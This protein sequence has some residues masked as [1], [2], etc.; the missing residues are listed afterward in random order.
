MVSS[1]ELLDSRRLT[2]PNLLGPSPGAV[3]DVRIE[4]ARATEFVDA[5]RERMT[6]MLDAIGWGGEETIVRAFEGGVNLAITAP[7]D[8]LYAA[9]EVNEWAVAAAGGDGGDFEVARARLAGEI[10]R[11]RDPALLALDAAATEHGVRFLSD[12]EFVSVGSGRGSQTW[13]A[14]ELPDPN[15]VNWNEISDV[16]VALI[17]GTNGKT[18]TTRLLGAIVKAAGRIAGMTSTDGVIVGGEMVDAGDWSGP[19]GARMALQDRRVEIALLETARGGLLRRGIGVKN[20]E[21]ALVTNIGDDHLGEFGVADLGGLAE[22]KLVVARAIGASGRL[23]LNADDPELARR[24]PRCGVPLGWFG[25]S[26]PPSGDPTAFVDDGRIVIVEKGN[27]IVELPIADVPLAL[28]GAARHNVANAMAAALV[29]RALDLSAE[30]IIGGLTSLAPSVTEN[31][32]RLNVFEV[33]GATAIVDFA[34][35]PQG[36]EALL[37]VARALPAKRRL[38]VIGQAGDRDDGSIRALGTLA[39]RLAPDRFVLKEMDHYLRG[40][41]PREVPGMIADA[42]VAAGGSPGAVEYAPNELDAVE[43]A[44]AWARAGDQLILTVHEKRDQVIARLTELASKG[45]E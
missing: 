25:M 3:C 21:A 15:D 32:G 17:T 29:A 38:V 4:E 19:G 8:V 26:A 12:D 37:D 39:G 40:R 24:G 7:I 23:I 16:P 10:E 42:F 43:R 30:A 28:G 11:E 18:T 31:P 9:T 41:A 35:N 5:W 33:G 6:T 22:T 34:H 14:G 36:F 2:G 20:A 13:A 45:V 1:S 27:R 44:L